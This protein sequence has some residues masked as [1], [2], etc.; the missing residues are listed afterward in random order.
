LRCGHGQRSGG[1]THG[2]HRT[3]RG[4]RSGLRANGALAAAASKGCSQSSQQARRWTPPYTVRRLPIGEEKTAANLGVILVPRLA[5]RRLRSH[6]VREPGFPRVSRHPCINIPAQ[7]AVDIR[8][9]AA[10]SVDSRGLGGQVNSRVAICCR[11]VPF[12]TSPRACSRQRAMLSDC[13]LASCVR[14][15]CTRITGPASV[16]TRFLGTR[17]KNIRKTT[18]PILRLPKSPCA[19]AQPVAVC[20]GALRRDT[21]KPG[22]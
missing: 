2:G 7:T 15:E 22:D 1:P 16:C 17:G 5:R 11:S 19:K 21:L 9:A 14:S 20:A 13:S 8:R 4:P 6:R 3:R 10:V 12:A 18:P